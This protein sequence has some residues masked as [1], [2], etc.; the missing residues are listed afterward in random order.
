[1]ECR[2]LAQPYRHAHA[3]HLA[4][5][6]AS[7]KRPPPVCVMTLRR[8][9]NRL[10]LALGHPHAHAVGAF[11][12]NSL[13]VVLPNGSA[14]TREKSVH[15]TLCSIKTPPIGPT[16]CFNAKPRRKEVTP[17]PG[18]YTA[19]SSGGGNAAGMHF[20]GRGWL[21]TTRAARLTKVAA[22]GRNTEL[23][24][25]PPDDCQRCVPAARTLRQNHDDHLKS[26]C[27]LATG[28][29]LVENE[30]R[31]LVTQRQRVRKKTS[32]L[33]YH[34]R[35]H[36]DQTADGQAPRISEHQGSVRRQKIRFRS[37]HC[38]T[39]RPC[40]SRGSLGGRYHSQ[41]RQR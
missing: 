10:A 21:G 29:L 36:V 4:A 14:S 2:R 20:L 26:D 27:L 35:R 33:R 37:S 40:P 39:A 17:A 5:I 23:A 9:F 19:A 16:A 11:H 12:M 7:G 18:T 13:D 30:K 28:K 8:A 38:K 6:T 22:M 24:S 41:Q 34:G 3:P 32:D 1:M 25:S 31:D 15:P